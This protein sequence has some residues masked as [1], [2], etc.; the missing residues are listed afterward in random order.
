LHDDASSLSVN[1][2]IDFGYG[3]PFNQGEW[4]Q[5][6]PSSIVN[7]LP[8]IPYPGMKNVTFEDL[9]ANGAT[10][11]LGL[12]NAQVLVT[13]STRYRVPTRLR[14]DGFSLQL[15]TESQ[16]QFLNDMRPSDL[17]ATVFGNEFSHWPTASATQRAMNVATFEHTL[18]KTTR[19]VAHQVWPHESALAVNKYV[20]ECNKELRLAKAWSA[21]SS[22]L[23]GPTFEQ[24]AT[25]EL[26]REYFADGVR[27]SL[28]LPPV[29]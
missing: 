14:N 22:P 12:E 10:P 26:S 5:E 29:Y 24:W 9:T 3:D 6:N 11:R 15:P 2:Q 7:G 25:T 19:S 23:K 13:S 20:S 1:R 4:I 27:E 21:A 18:E 17:E 16:L 8:S 28:G